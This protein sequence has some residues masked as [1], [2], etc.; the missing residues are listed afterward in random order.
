MALLPTA[1]S[2][3]GEVRRETMQ[4]PMRDGL[5]LVADVYRDADVLRAPAVLMRTPYDR[6]KQSP[7]AERFARAGYVAVIQDS[8]G[9]HGSQGV[10]SPYNNE[11]QD[12]YDTIEWLVRQP[13]CSGRVGMAGSSYVGAV[14]WQ[15]AVEQPP[16]LVAIAPQAT[17]SSFHRNL[18]LGGAVRL[19]LIAGWIAGNTPRPE[20]VRPADMDEALRRLPLSDVDEAIG[21]PMPWLDAFLTHPEPD[22]FWTRLDLAPHLPELRLPA[23]HVVGTYDFFSRESVDTFSLMQR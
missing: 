23:L 20:G 13:W 4:V 3:G 8:R 1:G 15:A 19:S 10:F 12:G 2:F 9:T 17:W 5:N 16:G 18:Y 22:G 11:G 7:L 6:T 21:W 14:Q